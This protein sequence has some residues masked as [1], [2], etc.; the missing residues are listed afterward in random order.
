MQIY[1]YC[2]AE[3]F[4]GRKLSQICGKHMSILWRKPS[5]N[6]DIGG[7]GMPKISWRK[8]THGGRSQTAN[9][10]KVFSLETSS[11]IPHAC[12]TGNSCKYDCIT[13]V[14]EGED[15]T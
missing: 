1:H 13:S 6:A 9:L 4:R 12:R 8:F 10:V 2:I 11:Y 3:N 15:V 5:R 7:C 14:N